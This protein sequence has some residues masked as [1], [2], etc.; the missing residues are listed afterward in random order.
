MILLNEE[1]GEGVILG[2]GREAALQRFLSRRKRRLRAWERA[3]GGLDWARHWVKYITLTYRPGVEWEPR[4]ITAYVRAVRRKLGDKLVAVLWWAE[5]QPDRGAVHYNLVLVYRKGAGTYL[6][7][8]DT[9]GM[10]PHGMSSI[11][12][13][14][15]AGA[16]VG[17]ALTQYGTKRKQIEGPF[18]RG[19]R[20]YMVWI[21]QAAIPK[22]DHWG[23]RL[24]VLPAWLETRLLL[25]W[26]Q[27]GRPEPPVAHRCDGGGWTVGVLRLLSPWSTADQWTPLT[28][29]RTWEYG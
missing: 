13:L 16:G 12:N 8:P 7:A 15:R 2:M 6:P 9:S 27:D 22:V 1:T 11:D 18:P 5:L 3:L 20:K 29:V 17:Y 28:G 26:G 24:S 19:L 25:M 21:D 23:F 4:Q 10:W 14:D